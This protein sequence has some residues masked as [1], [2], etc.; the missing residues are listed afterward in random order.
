MPDTEP[1]HFCDGEHRLVTDEDLNNRMCPTCKA[2][3]DR[4]RAHYLPL[5]RAGALDPV[6]PWKPRQQLID[7]WED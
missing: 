2:D 1:C 7:E 5:Y 6:G 3:H 4:Q